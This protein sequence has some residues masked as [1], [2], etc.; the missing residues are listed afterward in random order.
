MT[1]GAGANEESAYEESAKETIEA[2]RIGW[3]NTRNPL[4]AWK[5]I[6]LCFGIST[7]RVWE[8]TGSLPA[9]PITKAHPFP[10]WCMAYLGIAAQRLSSLADGRDYRVGPAPF[11]DGPSN[12]EA[13]ERYWGAKPDLP[14]AQATDLSLW[15]LGLRRN[16]ST[17]FKDFH[18][19][20]EKGLDALSFGEFKLRGMSYRE[21]IEAIAEEGGIDVRA[22]QK[23]LQAVRD[24][25]KSEPRPTPPAQASKPRG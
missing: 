13:A 14:A 20:F 10:D 8:E 18:S 6:S 4:F 11:G 2:Y 5:A 19:L 16:G 17:A 7:M 23:R 22:V 15:A 25:E 1:T 24:A 3:E 9:P 21:A 12:A